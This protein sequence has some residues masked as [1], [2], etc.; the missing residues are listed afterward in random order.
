MQKCNW[1][2]IQ[3]CLPFNFHNTRACSRQGDLAYNNYSICKCQTW[4]KRNHYE[5]SLDWD[6][7]QYCAQHFWQITC[8]VMRFMYRNCNEIYK[9]WMAA[10]VCN[11]ALWTQKTWGALK[12]YI[13][14]HKLHYVMAGWISTDLKKRNV[15]N[16][17][18]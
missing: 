7:E 18:S 10:H 15:L 9:E 14:I 4:G 8:F 13:Y 16:Y 5:I 17:F 1:Q 12:H 3:G 2:V 11:E 6:V